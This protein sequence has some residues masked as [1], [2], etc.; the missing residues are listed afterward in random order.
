MYVMYIIILFLKSIS[1]AHSVWL[2]LTIPHTWFPLLILCSVRY[3]NIP[4]HIIIYQ[5]Y[6]L[7]WHFHFHVDN[8]P[9]NIKKNQIKVELSVSS[10]NIDRHIKQINTYQFYLRTHGW[11]VPPY[12]WSICTSVH[13]EDMYLRTFEVYVSNNSITHITILLTTTR[14][15]QKKKQQCVPE[16]FIK[17][18]FKI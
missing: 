7:S 11:Y 9:T 13:M 12:T 6:E 10:K 17:I 3:V 2:V 4:A 14:K 15:K 8:V 16:Q 18:M 5:M 1:C